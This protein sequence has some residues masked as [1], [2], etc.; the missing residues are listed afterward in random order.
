[1]RITDVMTTTVV[2]VPARDPIEDAKTP[3]RMHGLGQLIVVEEHTVKGVVTAHQL[4]EAPPEQ[5][6]GV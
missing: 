3:L 4:A 6:V 5:L 1:M 2:Q